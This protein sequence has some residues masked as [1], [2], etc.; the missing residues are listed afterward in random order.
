MS[1][2]LLRYRSRRVPTWAPAAAFIAMVGAV[3]LLLFG[4]LS[5]GGLL[6]ELE[7]SSSTR[8]EIIA[9]TAEAA[10]DHLPV[11]SGVGTFASVYRTYEDPEAINYEWANH[12]HSDSSRSFS[13]RNSRRPPFAR[14]STLVGAAR[15]CDLD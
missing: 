10:I 12:V 4:P 9:I 7:T 1:V 2:L 3:V 11:G 8:Q 14:F 5:G 13:S 6:K 15:L